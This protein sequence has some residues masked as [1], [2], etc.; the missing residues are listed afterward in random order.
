MVMTLMEFTGRCWYQQRIR[1]VDRMKHLTSLND[2]FFENSTITYV[3]PHLLRGVAYK[4]IANRK[5]LSFGVI[6]NDLVAEV[7]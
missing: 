7:E 3:T 5:V 2:D 1:V 4:E 6:N